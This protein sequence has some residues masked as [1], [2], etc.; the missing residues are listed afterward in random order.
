MQA[1]TTRT[2]I[3]VRLPCAHHRARLRNREQAVRRCA[4]CRKYWLIKFYT[5]ELASV[6]NIGCHTCG[7]EMESTGDLWFCLSCG[8]EFDDESIRVRSLGRRLD[9]PSETTRGG[10][11]TYTV[12]IYGYDPQAGPGAL[13]EEHDFTDEDQAREAYAG[14]IAGGGWD[15]V[16]LTER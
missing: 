7:G 13:L 5:D 4:T 16:E 8:D 2:A 12:R 9:G 6:T 10:D 1:V 3:F 15:T 14:S 11:M